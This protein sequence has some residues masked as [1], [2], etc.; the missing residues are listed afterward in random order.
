MLSMTQLVRAAQQE[1]DRHASRQRAPVVIWAGLTESLEDFTE[2]LIQLR[3]RHSGR[4]LAAV[5]YGWRLPAGIQAVEFSAKMFSLLHPD[6][7]SRY[8]VASGGRGSGKSHAIAAALILRMLAAR[9]RVLCAREIQRSLRESV[10]HLLVAK[11]DE[12]RLGDFFDVNDREITCRTSGSEIIFAGLMANVQQLKSLEGV[13]LCWGEESESI[14]QRSFEILTPTIRAA[15]SEIWLSCNP[16]S[17]DAPIQGFIDGD[18]PDTRHEHVTFADNPWFPEPLE[19]ERAYLQSVDDDAYQHVWEGK[20]RTHS[21]AQVFRGKYRIEAFEPVKVFWAGP[22][23]GVDFGFAVDPSVL[24][25]CWVYDRTLYIDYEAYGI[26]VDTHLLPAL[27]DQ[28]PE[29]RTHVS[30]ADC[31]RPETVSH[32]QQFGYPLMAS[33]SKWT[34]SVEDGVAHIRSY[35]SVVIHPRCT[36]TADEFRLYS[37]RVDRLTND[38][39]PDLLDKNNHVIDALRYALEPLIRRIGTWAFTSV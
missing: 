12:L 34:G 7:Y 26:G 32:M 21:D 9:L 11:I 36:H 23:F 17:P 29:A 38:V 28:V 24:V 5:P 35:E 19:G 15:S 18:R 6:V 13:N 22:F 37:Y 39:L 10:H 3:K 14:S 4:I 31:A 1:I 16:D 2:R 25:R 8:R 20:C 30:R 27:F 33:V